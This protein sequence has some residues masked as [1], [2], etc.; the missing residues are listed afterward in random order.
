MSQQPQQPALPVWVHKVPA[1][2]V[3]MYFV[4]T[5]HDPSLTNAKSASLQNAYDSALQTLSS[6]SP[7]TSL[8]DLLALVKAS[9]VVQD[10][11][12]Y[13]DNSKRSFVYYTLLSIGKAIE[14]TG[15]PTLPIAKGL[16]LQRVT[17][18][19]RGWRPTD[20]AYDPTS[21]LFA[22]DANGGVSRLSLI[23]NQPRLTQLFRIPGAYT[24][25]AIA[26]N[27]DAVF[28]LANSAVGGTI[29]KNTFATKTTT[30]QLIAPGDSC[31]GIAVDGP[32]IYL[33]NANKD[34]IIYKSQWSAKRSTWKF[35]GGTPGIAAY[36]RFGDRL[37]VADLSGSAYAVSLSD[38]TDQLL[39]SNL[40]R[41]NSVAASYLH[42][43]FASG[44]QVLFR[45]RTDGRG[46]SP[47]QDLRSLT[48][49]H[50]VGVVVDSNDQLWF[51][52]YDKKL[53]QGPFNLFN[54]SAAQTSASGT[55]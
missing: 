27:A 51:A 21:G 19:Q 36:D 45:A 6:K 20:L 23:N 3:S 43:L 26:V 40:G 7:A 11:A 54:E 53:V 16:R 28:V 14:T 31:A 18:S 1:S 35:V 48:G 49:G 5:G 25:V 22:L 29:F 32:A 50:I 46:E 41:V 30:E 55:D 15:L 8:P 10:S 38:G 44:K 17:F 42:F 52:D 13:Y 33:T 39:A 2:D 37:I 47:P 34:E 12:F 9:A 24:G 4:G